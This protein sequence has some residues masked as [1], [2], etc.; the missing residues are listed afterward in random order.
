MSCKN[1]IAYYQIIGDK[2]SSIVTIAH[3]T[4]YNTYTTYPSKKGKF[5]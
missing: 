2:H 5:F 1:N 4:R 3:F